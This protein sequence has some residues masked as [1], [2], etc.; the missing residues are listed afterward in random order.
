MNDKQLQLAAPFPIEEH[1]IRV[2]RKSK[3]N[4]AL[5][6]VYIDARNVMQRLDEAFADDWSDTYQQV[7]LYRNEEDKGTYKVVTYECAAICSLVAGGTTHTDVGTGDGPD[8]IKG[9]YSDALKRAAVKFGIGRYLYTLKD[10]TWYPT[11]NYGNL[12]PESLVKAKANLARQLGQTAKRPT[13]QQDVDFERSGV[14]VHDSEPEDEGDRLFGDDNGYLSIDTADFVE[15]CQNQSVND[16]RPPSMKQVDLVSKVIDRVTGTEGSASIVLE[17]LHATEG[18]SNTVVKELLDT[19]LE[20]SKDQASGNY[21]PNKN[22]K[23]AR[24]EAIKE[25]YGGL[26]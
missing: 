10:E 21:V 19:L 8:G 22:Y 1:S 16:T 2:M 17:A 4:T 6:A 25:I 9:A 24:V 18:Y 15:W 13:P 12:L 3:N 20:Q 23:P 14:Q 26:A 7:N 11:D 5:V